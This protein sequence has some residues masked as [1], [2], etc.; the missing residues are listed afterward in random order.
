MSFDRDPE[1]NDKLQRILWLDWSVSMPATPRPKLSLPRPS[2]HT[3]SEE[4]GDCR[5][6]YTAVK[7]SKRGRPIKH[8]AART[9]LDSD[10]VDTTIAVKKEPTLWSSSEEEDSDHGSR[11]SIKKNQRKRKREPS[12]PSRPCSPPIPEDVPL[13][14]LPTPP[15]EDAEVSSRPLTLSLTFNVPEG[16]KG[17]FVV[18]LDLSKHIRVRSQKRAKTGLASP[19]VDTTDLKLRQAAI[20]TKNLSPAAAKPLNRK[21]KPTGFLSLPAELRNQIY[22]LVFVAKLPIDFYLPRDF[23]RSAALL[24][25]CRQVHD[26]GVTLL[27]GQ[28]HF[29]FERQ[30]RSRGE[31]WDRD[32]TEVGFKDIRRFLKTIGPWNVSRLRTVSFLLDDAMPS[33]NPQLKTA[34][35]RRFVHDDALVDIIKILEKQAS[36]EKLR[37]SCHG[38]RVLQKT[39]YRFLEHLMKVRAD[40]VEFPVNPRVPDEQCGRVNKIDGVLRM[41]LTNIITREEKLYPDA[42][43]RSNKKGPP[44][45]SGRSYVDSTPSATS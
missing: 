5:I 1:T 23:S 33:G 30:F 25:T 11:R 16:H 44:K 29:I 7:Y 31:Y 35:E 2:T 3:Q 15:E 39:D 27:Y 13:R 18:N 42:A 10:F 26:E 14:E 40:V 21:K 8:S 24:R 17:P 32:W 4:L 45:K 43:K 9:S 36:L 22:N 28:N 6:P 37:L 41:Q 19:A 12:P 38:R 20:Q 34:E